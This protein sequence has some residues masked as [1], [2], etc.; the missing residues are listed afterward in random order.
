V[1]FV[2]FEKSEELPED[3]QVRPKHIL[4]DYEF[5]VILNEGEIVNRVALRRK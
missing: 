1:Q 5:I 2:D 4:I 3:G